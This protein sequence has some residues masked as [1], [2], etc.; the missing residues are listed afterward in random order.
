MFPKIHLRCFN[1]FQVTRAAQNLARSSGDDAD[2]IY[3]IPMISEL[4]LQLAHSTPYLTL[5]WLYILILLNYCP[6][7]FWSRV[8]APDQRVQ[9]H[10]E[11]VVRETDSMRRGNLET[12][13][14]GENEKS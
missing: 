3:N 6:Q 1:F 4:F 10:D 13:P 9:R 7:S 11:V 5:Q 12:P 8:L 2:A 14:D